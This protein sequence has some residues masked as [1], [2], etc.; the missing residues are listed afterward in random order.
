ML[1]RAAEFQDERDVCR[2]FT[3][4][5]GSSGIWP[6]NSYLSAIGGN[7]LYAQLN[8]MP[9]LLM[10]VVIMGPYVNKTYS[11]LIY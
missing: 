3:L 10:F 4:F 5:L 9:T 2:Y 1:L 6:E 8:L 7:S 11:L